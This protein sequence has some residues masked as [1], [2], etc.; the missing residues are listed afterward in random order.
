MATHEKKQNPYEHV[1]QRPTHFIAFGF[2]LGTLPRAPGTWGTLLGIPFYCLFSATS[3]WMYLSIVCLFFLYGVWLCDV[4]SKDLGVHDH[5]GIVWDEVVGMMLTLYLFKPSVLTVI[6]GF[7][8]FR[9]FDIL[10]P[11]PISWVDK[12]VRGGLG[13]MLDDVLAAIPA[14]VCLGLLS[15]LWV[16]R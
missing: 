11:W 7:I 13:V 14:W 1:W 10:K 9:I 2:G 15:L 16:T 3:W 8:L 12:K 6:F 4:V 5:K